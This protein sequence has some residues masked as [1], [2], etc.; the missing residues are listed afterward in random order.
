MEFK[1]EARDVRLLCENP[2][3]VRAR[4]FSVS[5]HHF[6]LARNIEKQQNGFLIWISAAY[7]FPTHNYV[8]NYGTDI[9]SLMEKKM[10]SKK[11][12]K[13]SEN[14]HGFVNNYFLIEKIE[15]PFWF[16]QNWG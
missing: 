12:A 11:E 9:Q 13:E 7:M 5:D 14:K 8:H 4:I 6:L 16:G 10:A 2:S 15:L 1:T 3:S